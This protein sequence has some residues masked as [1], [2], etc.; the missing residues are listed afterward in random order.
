[1]RKGDLTEIDSLEEL[2][3]LDPSYAE[4][5]RTAGTAG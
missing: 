4:M 1:M 5:Q 2:I 3:A